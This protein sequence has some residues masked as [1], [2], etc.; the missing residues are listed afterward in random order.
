MKK[1]KKKT[2]MSV[3]LRGA[4]VMEN[5]P[6]SAGFICHIKGNKQTLVIYVCKFV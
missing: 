2:K 6:E 4:P 5:S 3:F 1:E